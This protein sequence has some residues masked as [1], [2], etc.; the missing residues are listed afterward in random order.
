MPATIPV[1]MGRLESGTVFAMIT[2]APEK[3]PA[4]PTPATARPRMKTVEVGAAPQRTDPTS[5][6]PMAETYTHL[7]E[8]NV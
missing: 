6:N 1:Y 5:K 4:L 7:M 3:I 8:R 2:R